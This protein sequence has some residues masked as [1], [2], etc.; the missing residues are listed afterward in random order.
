MPA[1]PT[2]L[3]EFSVFCRNQI[4]RIADEQAGLTHISPVAGVT[5]ARHALGAKKPSL[6]Q[7]E[8]EEWSN[9]SQKS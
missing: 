1:N 7:M 8:G 3:Q 9:M 6:S 4:Q 5:P 2:P